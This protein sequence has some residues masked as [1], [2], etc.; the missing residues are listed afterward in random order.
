MTYTT[1]SQIATLTA[2]NPSTGNQTTRYVFRD[3]PCRLGIARADLLRAEIYPDSDDG[4]DPL[5]DGADGVYDRVEYQY[6]GRASGPS[7]RVRT[8]PSMPMR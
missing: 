6:D 7:G 2:Q 4:A 8:A 5:G 3:D 1:N